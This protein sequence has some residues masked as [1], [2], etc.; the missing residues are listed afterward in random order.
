MIRATDVSLATGNVGPISI[1]SFLSGSIAAIEP[2]N[3]LAAVTV[4]LEGS[5]T[6]VALVTRRALHD[7]GLA[8]GAP[9]RALVKAVALDEGGVAEVGR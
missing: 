2:D 1:R 6:I 7:L 9:V 8:V 5:G 3:A 4:A